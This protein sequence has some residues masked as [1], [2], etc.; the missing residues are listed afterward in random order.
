[1]KISIKKMLISLALLLPVVG[2][3]SIPTTIKAKADTPNYGDYLSG[4]DPEA[5]GASAD[6]ITVA[7]ANGPGYQVQ[8]RW[9]PKYKANW[10]RI[11]VYPTKL[12]FSMA[13]QAEQDT[14]YTQIHY[15]SAYEG[16][17]YTPMIYSPVHKV[18]ALAWVTNMEPGHMGAV[19]TSWV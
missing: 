12:I 1:M 7:T 11:V 18:R 16:V 17:Y 8:L 5:V 2:S 9:S 6:A 19:F 13:I 4:K 15:F 10:A 14:G 3:L